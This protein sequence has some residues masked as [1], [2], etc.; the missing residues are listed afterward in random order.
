MLATSGAQISTPM[1]LKNARRLGGEPREVREDAAAVAPADEEAGLVAE[2]AAD[3][4]DADHHRQR[5]VAMRRR[6]AAQR[7]HCLAFEKRADEDGDVSE[8]GDQLFHRYI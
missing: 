8:I 5:K 3:D 7:E 4:G 6:H 2:K 1:K